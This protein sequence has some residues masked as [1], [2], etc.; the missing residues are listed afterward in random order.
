MP[1]PSVRLQTRCVAQPRR[2]VKFEVR[3]SG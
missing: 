2:R 3:R 1:P